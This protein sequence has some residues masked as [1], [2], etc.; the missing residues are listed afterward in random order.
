MS[1][2]LSMWP[3]DAIISQDAYGKNASCCIMLLHAVSFQRLNAL[4][5]LNDSM[6]GHGT[7]VPSHVESWR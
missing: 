7:S 5:A 6:S 3:K 2:Q 4:L 1:F